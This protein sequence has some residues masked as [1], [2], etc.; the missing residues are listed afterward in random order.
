MEAVI[1]IKKLA[2]ETGV[3]TAHDVKEQANESERIAT[4][5]DSSASCT[6]LAAWLG[7][8]KLAAPPNCIKCDQ[9]EKAMVQIK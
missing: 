4:T 1:A 8:V 6:T 7:A 2:L 9:D 5:D 3:R